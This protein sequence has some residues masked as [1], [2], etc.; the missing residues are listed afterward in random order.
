MNDDDGNVEPKKKKFCGAYDLPKRRLGY[1]PEEIKGW[2]AHGWITQES[3]EKKQLEQ[4]IRRAQEK[5]DR[6]Y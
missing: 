1:T 3:W 4:E 2:E 6:P 5:R